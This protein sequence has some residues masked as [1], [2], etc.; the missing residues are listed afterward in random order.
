MMSLLQ[1][2]AIYC[3]RFL[4]TGLVDHI[5]VLQ[6]PIKFNSIF[7]ASLDF[8]FLCG[9]VDTQGAAPTKDYITF[10]PYVYRQQGNACLVRF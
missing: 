1:F 10:L 4:K 7:C 8:F 9:I 2:N 5:D 3:A 6:T